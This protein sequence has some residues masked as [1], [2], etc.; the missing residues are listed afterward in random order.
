MEDSPENFNICPSCGT[1]FGI[2]DVNTSIL[3]LRQNWLSTGPKWWSS[4]D[5]QPDNW[6]PLQQLARY[7]S[8]DETENPRLQT[9]VIYLSEPVIS[10]EVSIVRQPDSRSDAA[11]VDIEL[12]PA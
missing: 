7:L 6:N 11:I 10:R 1:E 9:H 3:A 8:T 2:H 4:V 5:P 12:I